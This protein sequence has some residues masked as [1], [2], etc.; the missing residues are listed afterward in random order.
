MGFNFVELF[1]GLTRLSRLGGGK[2]VV[3]LAGCGNL[4]IFCYFK[5]IF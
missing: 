2:F 5:S 1:P 3:Y 4:C